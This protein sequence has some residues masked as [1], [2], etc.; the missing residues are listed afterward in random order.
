MNRV[1]NRVY[2]VYPVYMRILDV[3]NLVCARERARVQRKF[4][5]LI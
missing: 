1:L 4:E 5:E 2:P 3:V